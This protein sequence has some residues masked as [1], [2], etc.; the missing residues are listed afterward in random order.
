MLYTKI[1]LIVASLANII[2]SLKADGPLIISHLKPEALMPMT[3]PASYTQ[4]SSFFPLRRGGGASRSIP[5]LQAFRNGGFGIAGVHAT[6]QGNTWY[7]DVQLGSTTA[8]LIL[9]TGSSDLWVPGKGFQCQDPAS[10][11]NVSESACGFCRTY[12]LGKEFVPFADQH[13]NVIYGDGT[14]ATGPMGNVRVELGGIT[15]MQKIGVADTVGWYGGVTEG[16]LG[17]AY[18][19]L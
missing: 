7:T 4:V 2:N 9:D 16:V 1:F 5:F 8:P 11:N 14:F 19:S 18:P 13:L 15:V 6:P 17:F 12:D 3:P 10:G